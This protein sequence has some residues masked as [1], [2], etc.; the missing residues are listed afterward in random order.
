M[1][2]LRRARRTPTLPAHTGPRPPWRW[3]ALGALLGLTIV[4]V[5]QAPARWLA[6]AVGAAPGATRQFAQAHRPRWERAAPPH[7]TA[8][9]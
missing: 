3:A 9:A 2:A 6:A 4:L 1:N 7:R 8:G 5:L